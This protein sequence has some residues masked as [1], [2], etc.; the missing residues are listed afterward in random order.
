MSTKYTDFTGHTLDGRNSQYRIKSALG[1]GGMATVYLAVDL[2]NGKEVA[3]K[4]PHEQILRE[5]GFAARFT[6]EIKALLKLAHPS[7]VKVLDVGEFRQAPF[8]VLQYLALGS[9]RLQQPLDLGDGKVWP[10]RPD[11]IVGWL[12]PMAE[13]IDYVNNRGFVHRDVKPENI[14]FDADGNAFLGDFGVIKARAEVHQDKPQTVATGAGLVLGTPHYM[15]PEVLMGE[16]YDGRADQYSLAVTV[17]ELLAARVPFPGDAPVAIVGH[18]TRPVPK[19]TVLVPNTPLAIE[20]VVLRGLAKRKEDRFP[21][22]RSFADAFMSAVRATMPAGVAVSAGRSSPP[23]PPRPAGKPGPTPPAVPKRTAAIVCPYC[24]IAANLPDHV[25]SKAIRCAGCRKVFLLD[26]PSSGTGTR[27]QEQARTETRPEDRRPSRASEPPRQSTPQNVPVRKSKPNIELPPEPPP[28]PKPRKPKG[29]PFWKKP[30]FRPLARKAMM[31]LLVVSLLGVGAYGI[32]IGFGWYEGRQAKKTSEM[33]EKAIDEGHFADAVKFAEE[34]IAK[35]SSNGP[36]YASRAR[37]R[38]FLGDHEGALTDANK[39]IELESNLAGAYA[40][41]SIV[42]LA[43]GHPRDALADADKAVQLDPKLGVAYAYL[44]MAQIE[45]GSADRSEIN[46]DLGVQKSP[47]NPEVFRA[48]AIVRHAKGKPTASSDIETAV[49]KSA[50]GAYYLASRGLFD[51]IGRSSL[52][53]FEAANFANLGPCEPRVQADGNDAI[54]KDATCGLGHLAVA[55]FHVRAKSYV[56]ALKSCELA[57]GASPKLVAAY[58]MAHWLVSTGKTVFVNTR[59]EALSILTRGLSESPTSP[60]LLRLQ[61]LQ[62]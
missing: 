45:T 1:S 51:A 43:R 41:R 54:K 22:C 19:L 44:G 17:Y 33:S 29:P 50:K 7:I 6:R 32:V 25:R 30:W 61:K 3:V 14:M 52:T 36:A 62:P 24:G 53:R 34:A 8:A 48:R 15:A 12:N 47:D 27:K 57:M 10:M 42:Q 4:L 37:A 9:L 55:A 2:K 58:E 16:A 56:Q 49:S 11:E 46:C 20:Q 59:A 40:T 35:D 26:A 21:D 60:H 5:E 28:P 38:Y 18:T 31:G 13:A 39:A 23:P